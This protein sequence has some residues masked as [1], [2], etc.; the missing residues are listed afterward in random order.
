MAGGRP[1]KGIVT[2]PLDHWVFDGHPV[3]KPVT[4][5]SGVTVRPHY[6]LSQ[7]ARADGSGVGV[8]LDAPCRCSRRRWYRAGRRHVESLSGAQHLQEEATAAQVRER[9]ELLTQRNCRVV[10]SKHVL[11]GRSQVVRET[12]SDASSCS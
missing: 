1:G 10:G 5:S 11:L 7:V 12:S 2:S 4:S 6:S 8:K 3:K 9:H